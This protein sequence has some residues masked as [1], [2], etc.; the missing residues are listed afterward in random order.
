MMDGVKGAGVGYFSLLTGS[1]V[2]VA[3]GAV[4]QTSI[5]R[6]NSVASAWYIFSGYLVT[7][8]AV[9]LGAMLLIGVPVCLFMRRRR[10][11]R[12]QTL[13][14]LTI[15]AVLTA[16]VV[17]GT[18]GLLSGQA[19]IWILIFLAAI[20]WCW[21]VAIILVRPFDALPRIRWSILGILIALLA[22]ASVTIALGL[23]PWQA[24]STVSI[25]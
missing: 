21:A 17:G 23:L 1:L 5:L 8:D 19:A 7:G 9:L 16:L 24:G 3:L 11:T 10:A 20:A 13:G 4:F 25:T 18:L 12:G 22:A 15:A 2:G 6:P 14:A